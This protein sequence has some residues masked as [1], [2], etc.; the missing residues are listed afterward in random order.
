MNKGYR[1][2]FQTNCQPDDIKNLFRMCCMTMEELRGRTGISM[3][4]RYSV[5]DGGRTY[6][7]NADNSN[8]RDLAVI[9]I[10]NSRRILGENC[11]SVTPVL[12]NG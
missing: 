10:G 2:R 3:S 7:V 5:S 12:F 11:C 1:I 4:C 6:E 8:A 9:F